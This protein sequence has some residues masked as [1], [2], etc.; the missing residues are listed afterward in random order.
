MNRLV[1]LCLVPAVLLTAAI[2]SSPSSANA[3]YGYGYGYSYG[4][5]PVY[6]K[7]YAPTYYH[8]YTP[9]YVAPSYFG[10]FCY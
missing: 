3:G 8:H 2:F 7:H 5:R 10:G 6:V 1:K 4:Y 9:T